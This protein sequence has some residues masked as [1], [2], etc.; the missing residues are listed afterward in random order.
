MDFSEKAVKCGTD[1]KGDL[2]V[3]LELAGKG[4]EIEVTSKVA[5]KYGDAIKEDIN[6]VLDQYKIKNAKVLAEDLGAF[7]FAIKARVETAVKRA[8]AKKEGK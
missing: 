6:E 1:K 7:D 3:T 8:Q 4:R 5:R 2:M